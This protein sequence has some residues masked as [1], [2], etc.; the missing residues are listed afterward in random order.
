[1]P[2]K[3]T[4]NAATGHKQ[5]AA[6]TSDKEYASYSDDAGEAVAGDAAGAEDPLSPGG[7]A[8]LARTGSRHGLAYDA[9]VA[10]GVPHRMLRRAWIVGAG[11]PDQVR[12]AA[13][14]ARASLWQPSR[15]SLAAS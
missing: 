15:E 3:V 9:L 13:E 4:K 12:A 5:Q 10:W 14:S 11:D 6:A 8:A 1:M 7:G 2:K